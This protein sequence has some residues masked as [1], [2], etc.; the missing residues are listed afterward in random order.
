MACYKN[1]SCVKNFSHNLQGQFSEF[2]SFIFNLNSSIMLLFKCILAKFPIFLVLKIFTVTSYLNLKVLDAWKV[3]AG[4]FLDSKAKISKIEDFICH[5]TLSTL[6]KFNLQKLHAWLR[7][8]PSFTYF[9][10]W[11]ITQPL[12][13][14]FNLTLLKRTYKTTLTTLF[15]YIT[16]TLRYLNTIIMPF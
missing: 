6:L 7:S 12:R 5:T 16:I 4:K 15:L 3:L 2:H 10:N 11:N 13:R 1:A 14:R 8:V 9:L